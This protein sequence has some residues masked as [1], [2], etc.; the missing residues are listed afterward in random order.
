MDDL[1]RLRPALQLIA[2]FRDLDPY[3]P[4]QTIDVFLTVASRAGDHGL[5]TRE[6]PALTDL[7][8]SS[9]NRALTYLGETHWKDRSKPGLNLLQFR[10]KPQDRRHVL[11]SLTP[12]GRRLAGRIEELF[13]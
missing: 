9:T 4:S 11:A 2:L 1:P 7:A 6:I 5:E 13:A 3:L 8:Q 10:P 12:K